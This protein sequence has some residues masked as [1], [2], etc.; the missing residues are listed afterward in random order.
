MLIVSVVLGLG[1]GATADASTEAG[2]SLCNGTDYR[3]R[4]H[5]EYIAEYTRLVQ[6]L[7]E[8]HVHSPES[9]PLI[10][11]SRLDLTSSHIAHRH[12]SGQ[13]HG[14]TRVG[15][16]HNPNPN[17][18]LG[19]HEDAVATT[20]LPLAQEGVLCPIVY[21]NSVSTG[22]TQIINAARRQL[23]LLLPRSADD[24]HRVQIR[25][26]SVSSGNTLA[27]AYPY[28]ATPLANIVFYPAAVADDDLLFVTAQHELLHLVGFNQ[29]PGGFFSRIDAQSNTYQSELVR[30]CVAEYEEVALSG[31]TIGV[32]LSS[33]GMYT[34]HWDSGQYGFDLMTP[35]VNPQSRLHACSVA[36]AAEAS[37]YMAE[38][39]LCRT[40]ADCE[41]DRY[42]CVQTT[43][44]NPAVCYPTS[45]RQTPV[46]PASSPI[47]HRFPVFTAF[48]VAVVIFFRQLLVCAPRYKTACAL[49][50]APKS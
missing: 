4:G 47:K 31:V 40:D 36:T 37:P 44:S 33:E 2:H 32:H 24:C 17:L 38:A 28:N 5:T 8:L 39:N 20:H 42:S 16:N 45:R 13:P 43:H 18:G 29:L 21:E 46:T 6:H 23:Q 30:Q 10:L 12:R 1:F 25:V 3:G 15:G 22:Q 9:L 7:T 35:Y 48:F 26:S 41:T 19:S 50:L 49:E 11:E 14:M 34:G 27:A